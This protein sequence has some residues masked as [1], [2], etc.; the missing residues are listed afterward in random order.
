MSARLRRQRRAEVK[1]TRDDA[2]AK[3]GKDPAKLKAA[4]ALGDGALLEAAV[5]DNA[6]LR[7]LGLPWVRKHQAGFFTLPWPLVKALS[8]EH[9]V[10]G[11]IFHTVDLHHFQLPDPPPLP[12]GERENVWFPGDGTGPPQ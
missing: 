8:D 12:V 7:R 1:K 10:W 3:A 2:T 11:A 5:K 4:T 6:S 9:C